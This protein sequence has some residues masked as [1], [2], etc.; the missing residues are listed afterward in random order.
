[1]IAFKVTIKEN[2]STKLVEFT[3]ESADAPEATEAEIKYAKAFQL[4]CAVFKE[5]LAAPER[6]AN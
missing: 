3:H 6:D 1:M 4:S 5:H 2:S